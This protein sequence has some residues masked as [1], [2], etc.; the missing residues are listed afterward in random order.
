M[1]LM[2]RV[3]WRAEQNLERNPD[4]AHVDEIKLNGLRF[5][6]IGTVLYGFMAGTELYE[7]HNF[8]YILYIPVFVLLRS[9]TSDLKLKPSLYAVVDVPVLTVRTPI[10][11]GRGVVKHSACLIHFCPACTLQN[12]TG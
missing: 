5:R 7:S 8:Q 6:V 11:H 9:C 3:R 10:S 1:Q 2:L 12:I 4:R